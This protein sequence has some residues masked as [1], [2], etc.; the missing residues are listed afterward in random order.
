LGSIFGYVYI[1]KSLKNA[2]FYI[3]STNNLERRL[4]EHNRGLSKYTSLNRPFELVF[5][6]EFE[7]ETVA[8]QMEFKL[9]QLKNSK[10]LEKIIVAGK[11]YLS[12]VGKI[13][14]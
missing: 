8:R 2:T 1:L 13:N 14:W 12:D 4:D 6:Q 3:G 5:S 7:N 10:I 11:F 9:K